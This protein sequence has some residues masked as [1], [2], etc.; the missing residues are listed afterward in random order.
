M[1]HYLNNTQVHMKNKHLK[2]CMWYILQYRLNIKSLLSLNNTQQYISHKYSNHCNFDSQ[3]EQYH[4]W[5][6]CLLLCWDS[7]RIHR[8]SNG[9]KS[10]IIGS[11]I[12]LIGIMN[13]CI[14]LN[15]RCCPDS[16]HQGMR[17]N[18]FSCMYGSNGLMWSILG[19]C[20]WRMLCS[21]KSQGCSLCSWWL[22]NR[23]CRVMNMV[24]KME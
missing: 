17:S 14:C 2:S 22:C 4:M 23:L 12:R 21:D 13:I 9:L 6:I 3:E 10:C 5:C 15:L 11:L 16:I 18:L 24:G 8:Q 7:S 1:S 19:M 20:C